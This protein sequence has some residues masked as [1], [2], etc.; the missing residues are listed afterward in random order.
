MR[1]APHVCPRKKIMI[2]LTGKKFGK[3][4]V[5]CHEPNSNRST[6]I[7]KCDCGGEIIV[8]GSY[9]RFDRIQSCGC[10]L[11]RPN[12]KLINEIGNKYGKLIVIGRG[13]NQKHGTAW[14][15]RCECGKE[16]IVRGFSL[17]S[18]WTKSCGYMSC[19]IGKTTD[20]FVAYVKKVS[21]NDYEVLGDYVNANT[22]ILFRHNVCG[23]EYKAK[24]NSFVQGKRCM[25]CFRNSLKLQD[26]TNRNIY[27]NI[28]TR[29]IHILRGRVKSAPTMELMDCSVEELKAHIERQFEHGMNWAN[30]G[31]R[32]G[33]QIDHIRPC[34]S[35]DD[36]TD[37]KQQRECFHYTNLQPLWT[38]ENI[39][40]HSWWNGILY[41]SAPIGC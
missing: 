20:E 19:L 31:K 13:K 1:R 4:V 26:R 37:P 35:F 9:L 40:K 15:C 32:D 24:P 22:P 8:T 33:W 18:G 12:E 17:R 14:L 6:W 23:Y 30:Y 41:R 28:S 3:L 10:L 27:R 2:D 11:H 16:T 29:L 5:A 21:G 38:I 7:C 25:K 36:F 39:R 34:A